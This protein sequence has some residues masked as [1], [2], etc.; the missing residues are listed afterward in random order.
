[1]SKYD[2]LEVKAKAA[3]GGEWQWFTSNSHNRLS[4]LESGKDGDVIS[5][6]KAVD[7]MACVSVS[8]PNMAFI[9]S[10]NPQTVLEQLT[11]ALRLAKLLGNTGIYATSDPEPPEAA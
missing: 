8:K 11:L 1:M 5:A 10:A 7:G 4:S 6:F 2:D 9:A 3:T